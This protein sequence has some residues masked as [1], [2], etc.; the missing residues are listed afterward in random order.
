LNLAYDG[1]ARATPF[2]GEQT[3]SVFDGE[4]PIINP[5]TEV[6]QA[7]GLDGEI[8]V[9]Q[10]NNAQQQGNSDDFLDFRKALVMYR[11]RL[12]TVAD[13]ESGQTIYVRVELFVVDRAVDYVDP[14]KTSEAFEIFISPNGNTVF[15]VAGYVA[16]LRALETFSQL[17]SSS[18][19][20]DRLPIYIAD[21]PSFSWRS[22]LL[23]VSTTY[24]ELDEIKVL[25]N[26]MQITKLNVLSL[27]IT[28]TESFPYEL[29]QFPEV[30][31]QGAFSSQQVY[32]RK[33]LV[34][35]IQYG[36]SRGVVVVPELE[37]PVHTHSWTEWSTFSDINACGNIDEREWPEYCAQPPCGQLD[38]T[39]NLTSLLVYS[40]F[41]E[42]QTIFPSRY[43]HLGADLFTASCFDQKP[44]I[45][46]YMQQNNITDYY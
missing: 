4:W 42:V 37:Q 20:I 19:T 26:G 15:R 11:N 36:Q 18:G 3:L 6:E 22:L 16:F 8:F 39:N 24:I 10:G 45:K 44:S 43:V 40:V 25:I 28:D 13:G 1:E 5:Q 32:T 9:I 35:L 2:D 23:D 17:V 46:K 27:L 12:A 7:Y 29:V 21:Y 38:P 41:A 33:D 30:T 14:L 31:A 34:E